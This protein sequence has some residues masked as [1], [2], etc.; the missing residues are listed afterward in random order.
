M[1]QH[2]RFASASSCPRRGVLS[3]LGAA[4]LAA[5][6]FPSCQNTGGQLLSLSETVPPTLSGNKPF[7]HYQCYFFT[8]PDDFELLKDTEGAHVA[9]IYSPQDGDKLVESLKRQRGFH[10]Q[11]APTLTSRQGQRGK[12]EVVREF[13][14]PTEY[15][16]PQIPENALSTPTDIFPVTPASPT[17]FETR[18]VGFSA[19][20]QG[21]NSSGGAIDFTFSLERTAFLGFVN[22]GS[23]IT[24]PA[25]TAFG[26]MVDVTITE[27]R[28]EM[29]VFD[30]KRLASKLT[31]S[32]GHY[33]AIGG[34]RAEPQEGL[35]RR[36]EK[37]P[38]PG[39]TSGVSADESLFVL[40]KVT[41]TERKGT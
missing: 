27:N 5:C 16:P 10:L 33:V 35:T 28:I 29:P 12:I 6:L 15:A 19:E 40:I 36:I 4:A 8:A 39:I 14:Y 18:K 20:F 25:K 37:A 30:V 38:H 23:P 17:K 9:G 2:L 3:A 7:I 32:D 31:L 24:A 1:N 41:A 22:Y 34:L 26:R 21:S 11:S 13:N